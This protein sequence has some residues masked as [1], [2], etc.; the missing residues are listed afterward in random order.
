MFLRVVVL[1]TL[2]M[3]LAYS[4]FQT[5][6]EITPVMLG[7]LLL[8]AV[9]ELFWHL[10]KQERNWVRFLQSVKYRDFNRVYEK[11]TSSKE[12]AEAYNLITESMEELQSGRE[13]E[14]RLLQTVLGHIPIAVACF[15]EDGEMVFT[16]KAF[17][18]LLQLPG[19][20][21]LEG[22]KKDYPNI[23]EVMSTSNGVPSEWID[24]T[25]GQKLLVKNEAFKLKGKRHRLISL[26]DIRSSLDA[27]ELESYQKLMRVMTHEIMNSATPVLSLIRVVNEKLIQGQELVDLGK[28]DQANI[29]TS[30]LAI[31]ERTEGILKFVEAYK[32]VNQSITPLPAPVA[33]KELLEMVTALIK[34]APHIEL[35]VKDS[36]NDTLT[37][38]RTLISQVLLNLIK[39]ALDAAQDMENAHIVISLERKDDSILICIEDNG[40]G[41]VP[42]DI[43]QIFVPFYTT[44]SDGS[45]IGLALSRKIVRAH[46]GILEYTRVDDKT[47]FSLTIPQRAN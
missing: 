14:F 7:I 33:S 4:W 11:Q 43:H 22:L 2:S 24:H 36:W 8:V 27:K 37:L 39:N 16:N 12:L 41:I 35:K 40:P 28:K 38:D 30:L 42:K 15:Q 32:Q 6:L 3:G 5:E 26:T 19:L 23:Y 47:R 9:L 44:K 29:S 25:D 21:H 1:T 18:T 17:D 31:E 13:A 34:P 45:G 46:G 20:I 10:Q